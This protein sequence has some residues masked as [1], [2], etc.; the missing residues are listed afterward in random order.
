MQ[1]TSLYQGVCLKVENLVLLAVLFI[2]LQII[3]V[4]LCDWCISTAK[5]L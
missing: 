2:E 3:E 5:Q 4:D 1:R